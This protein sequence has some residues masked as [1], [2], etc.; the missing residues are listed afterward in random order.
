VISDRLHRPVAPVGVALRPE[1]R[2]SGRQ[3]LGTS[4]WLRPGRDPGRWCDVLRSGAAAGQSTG[5]RA[6][7]AAPSRPSRAGLG[8]GGAAG[9]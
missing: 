1:Q 8:E 6:H 9:V 7:L 2:A 5:G 4:R 3:R